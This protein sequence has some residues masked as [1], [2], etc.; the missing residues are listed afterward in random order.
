MLRL[1]THDLQLIERLLKSAASGGSEERS[2]APVSSEFEFQ[3]HDILAAIRA[4]AATL[5][6]ETSG[7]ARGIELGADAYSRGP[8]QAVGMVAQMAALRLDQINLRLRDL[9]REPTRF[10]REELLER[11]RFRGEVVPDCIDFLEEFV[12]SVPERE[13]IDELIRCH[14]LIAFILL[15]QISNE[16]GM[17]LV[18]VDHRYASL[19]DL[20]AKEALDDELAWLDWPD[21]G[22]PPRQPD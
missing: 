11:M 12:D 14:G 18:A 2:G 19:R 4:V 5:A 20:F 15:V 6:E 3:V 7:S 13:S 21:T 9:G 16:I 10:P 1:V 17:M 22:W 8:V